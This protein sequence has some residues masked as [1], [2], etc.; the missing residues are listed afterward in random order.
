MI[1]RVDQIKITLSGLSICQCSKQTIRSEGLI[2]YAIEHQSECG[3]I[4]VHFL[5]ISPFYYF[6]QHLS[7]FPVVIV[8][9]IVNLIDDHQLIH[10][11]RINHIDH[12]R[13][14]ND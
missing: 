9:R 13:S 1:E 8:D 2:D 14:I 6:F 3:G 12:I 5:K 4:F 7:D 11:P 10:P